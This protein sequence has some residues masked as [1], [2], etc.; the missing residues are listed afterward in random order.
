[1][2]IETPNRAQQKF[3]DPDV[4]KKYIPI[5]IIPASLENAVSSMEASSN[6]AEHV[7]ADF[8]LVLKYRGSVVCIYATHS[9]SIAITMSNNS[10]LA[11]QTSHYLTLTPHVITASNAN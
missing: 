1:M 8:Q 9:S 3:L 6:P 2:F 5:I 4:R 10:L 11:S 7:M